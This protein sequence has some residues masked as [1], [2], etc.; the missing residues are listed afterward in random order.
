MPAIFTQEL[1]NLTSGALTTDMAGVIIGAAVCVVLFIAMEWALGSKGKLGNEGGSIFL[2]SA[3]VGIVI[4]V[5]IG[6]WP[7][8]SVIFIGLVLALLIISPFGGRGSSA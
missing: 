5:G 1:S 4:S 8:W 3:G 6:W 2:I 7:L